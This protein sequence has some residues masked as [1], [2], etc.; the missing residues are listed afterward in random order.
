MSLVKA[1]KALD[2]LWSMA[3]LKG[4]CWGR[5]LKH[6]QNPY[7]NSNITIAIGDELVS[8]SQSPDNSLTVHEFSK[9]ENTSL[10]K[11][12]RTV[13]KAEGLEIKERK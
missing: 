7:R 13:L 4:R 1:R 6:A 9:T 10:G 2:G 12:V 8:I 11:Q 3:W 5:K